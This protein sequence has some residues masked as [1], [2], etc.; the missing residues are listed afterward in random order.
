MTLAEFLDNW[1]LKH[2]YRSAERSDAP[3]LAGDMLLG[4]SQLGIERQD[5]EEELGKSLEEYIAERISRA[6]QERVW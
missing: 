6:G 1:L 4:A 5:L 3:R 2:I